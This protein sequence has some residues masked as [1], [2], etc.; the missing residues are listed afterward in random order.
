[1]KLFVYGTLK[2]SVQYLT[3]K[4]LETATLKQHDMYR[5][6]V[7]EFPFITPGDG[8]IKGEVYEI[9]SL[10]IFDRI[11]GYP[12]LY[13]RKEVTVY[14]DKKHKAWVY[15]VGDAQRPLHESKPKKITNW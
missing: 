10:G 8:E 9:I 3:G 6:G 14:G 13:D 2:G 15:Y 11:E 1:M 12:E 4:F 7:G 5:S